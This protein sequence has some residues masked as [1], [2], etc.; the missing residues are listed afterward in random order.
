MMARQH[1]PAIIFIDEI[2]AVGSTLTDDGTSG[3]AEAQ[4][5]LMQLF[6]EMDW[7]DDIGN[8]G[9]VRIIAATNRP[10][11]LDPALLR[12]GRFERVIEVPLPDMDGRLQILKIHTHD[13]ELANVDLEAIAGMTD[14]T[15]G[16]ELE[17]ICREAG[18][19]A[20]RRD[21]S[22]VEMVDFTEAVNRV[23]DEIVTYKRM[24]TR[25]A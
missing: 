18:M 12:P 14:N 15:A 16:A 13:V 24:N 17:V 22:A 5:T 10:D 9:D 11:M 8:W 23:Q 2:D 20:V 25:S 7:F 6:S 1:A 3:S 21:A 19:M 4:R